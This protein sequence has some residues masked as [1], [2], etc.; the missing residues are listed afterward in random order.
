MLGSVQLEKLMANEIWLK[1][2]I[3][4][5]SLPG[6]YDAAETGTYIKVLHTKIT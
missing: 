1:K 6:K 5:V 3:D 2:G 4:L